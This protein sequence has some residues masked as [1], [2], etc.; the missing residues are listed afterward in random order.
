MGYNILKVGYSTG[1][2]DRTNGGIFTPNAL[3]IL[4][5]S[6]FISVRT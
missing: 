6:T 2:S 5:R 1:N 4:H 3:N